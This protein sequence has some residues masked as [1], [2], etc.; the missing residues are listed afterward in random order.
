MAP[1]PGVPGLG[2]VPREIA[3]AFESAF[4]PR[5]RFGRPSAADW[6]AMLKRLRVELKKCGR[7]PLHFHPAISGDCPWCKMRDELGV[8]AFVPPPLPVGKAPPASN[9]SEGFDIFAVW[10]TI[11]RVTAPPAALEPI[12]GNIDLRPSPAAA[13]ARGARTKRKLIGV[14]AVAAAAATLFYAPAAWIIWIAVGWYGLA[15]LF[16]DGDESSFTLS[17]ERAD[18]EWAEGLA[19]WRASVGGGRFEAAKAK[20]AQYRAQYDSLAADERRKLE[21]ADRGRRDA[22]LKAWLE[23]FQIRRFPIKGI[24]PGKVATLASYGIETA[25]EIE[26]SRLLRVPGFGSVT[27][28]PLLEWRRRLE[29]RFRYDARPTPADAQRVASIRSEIATKA[30]KLRLELSA[31]PAE[32]AKIAASVVAAQNSPS[33]ELIK[34]R[35]ARAQ[36]EADL[37]YL[38]ISVP[39][40]RA[41]VPSPVRQPPSRQYWPRSGPAQRSTSSRI[42]RTCPK[43]GSSMVKRT[44]RRGRNAGGQFWGCSRYPS[45]RGTRST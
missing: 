14:A 44:A 25:A 29:G 13:A 9:W 37:R 17:F 34:L 40:A 6:V 31:G 22:Q 16:G 12:I 45:C 32:L 8:E 28:R 3:A 36:A 11:E 35:S 1:P 10:Q 42:G 24:G 39:A 18:R 43:C 41:Y 5:G 19:R 21:E 20:L 7:N 4:A 15:I 38:G 30:A 26:S 23:Q 33:S 27:S 2:Y